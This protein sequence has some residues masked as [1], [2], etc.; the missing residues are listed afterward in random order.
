[1][2]FNPWVELRRLVELLCITAAPR[3]QSASISRLKV[4]WTEDVP[5]IAMFRSMRSH[6]AATGT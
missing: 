4:S 6:T 3:F 1:M 2:Y 5:I